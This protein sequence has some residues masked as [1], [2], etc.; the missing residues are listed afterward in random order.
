MSAPAVSDGLAI[1]YATHQVF[2]NDK[3]VKLT[4]IEQRKVT[5]EE[6]MLR[7]RSEVLGKYQKEY[8]GQLRTSVQ[9]V[10]AISGGGFRNADIKRFHL[11]ISCCIVCRDGC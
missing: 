7:A 1:N 9:Q 2:M 11:S 4:P 10:A 8:P 5:Q 3:A 6:L